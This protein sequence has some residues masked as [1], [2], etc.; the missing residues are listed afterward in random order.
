M[1]LWQ[2]ST[3]HAPEEFFPSWERY[4]SGYFCQYREVQVEKRFLSHRH[5]N[6]ETLH[7]SLHSANSKAWG[8]KKKARSRHTIQSTAGDWNIDMT[9]V[10]NT[11]PF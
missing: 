4:F 1:S 3:E 8:I 9:L 5:S 6:T 7:F 11:S 10:K 2:F